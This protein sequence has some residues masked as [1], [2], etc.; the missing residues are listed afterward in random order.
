[1]G[2]QQYNL[3]IAYEREEKRDTKEAKKA[4]KKKE[5]LKVD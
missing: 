2:P 4:K 3:S 5:K 1:M